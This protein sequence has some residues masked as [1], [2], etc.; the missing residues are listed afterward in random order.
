MMEPNTIPSISEQLKEL[1]K[2]QN[3]IDEAGLKLKQLRQSI[4][5]VKTKGG[6]DRP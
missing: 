1:E 2:L 3:L 6:E 4:E 5:K